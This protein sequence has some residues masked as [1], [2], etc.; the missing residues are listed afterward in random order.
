MAD[1][2]LRVT[3]GATK[4]P[5]TDPASATKPSRITMIEGISPVYHRITVGALVQ[6]AATPN[7]GTEGALDGT[8]GGRLFSWWFA[9]SPMGGAPIFAV[10]PGNSSVMM[11]TPANVGSYLAVAAR[12]NG[13]RV[14]L[15]MRCE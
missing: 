12:A 3:L 15:H 7:G 14:A 1:Y 11:F 6:I 13:G 8:L 9:E 4:R 10:P 2:T 5:W